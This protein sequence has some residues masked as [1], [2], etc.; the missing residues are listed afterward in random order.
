M[1]LVISAGQAINSFVAIVVVVL[2]GFAI[3]IARGVDR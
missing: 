3:F 2:V 1:L